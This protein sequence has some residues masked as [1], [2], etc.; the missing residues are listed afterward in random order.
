MSITQ[1]PSRF[2]LRIALRL[3]LAA[4]AVIVLCAPA[5]VF[6]CGSNGSFG[7]LTTAPGETRTV[8]LPADGILHVT[9]MSIA[10]YSSLQFQRNGLNTP[11][12]ILCQG[13]VV[14]YGSINVMGNP[15]TGTQGGVAGP[16]GFDGG[17]IAPNSTRGSDG[18]GPGAGAGSGSGG[19]GRGNHAVLVNPAPQD[20]TAYGN[21]L[22]LPLIG[23]SGGGA[24]AYYRTL[25]GGGG[26]AVLV[27][28]NTTIRLDG[29]ITATGGS[30]NGAAGGIRLV[31]PKVTGSG[32][33]QV[34][35]PGGRG[36]ARIDTFDPT[37]QFIVF[38]PPEARVIGASMT[39]FPPV[40]K[41][42]EIIDVAGTTIDPSTNAPVT[43]I[44]AP[45]SETHLPVTVRATNFTGSVN[46]SVVLTPRSL[47]RRT[48]PLTIN[49]G[50][51]ATASGTVYVDF[52]TNMLTRVD[53]W[54]Q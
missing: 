33:V 42:V 49:M 34:N 1:S 51:N 43:I 20:G 41:K 13:D 2:A 32:N 29:Y 9:T 5:P 23:G 39:I 17:E 50:G 6:D 31:A 28:S 3:A 4:G 21:V 44:R 48:Y 10:Q 40:E 47:P 15:G 22:Q 7:E 37:E 30:P 45:D 19:P 52:D 53:A 36:R 18:Y 8:Q 46:V 24:D 26:G 27:A 14:I 16:G 38:Y 12:H 25:G 35:G 54:V 11:V